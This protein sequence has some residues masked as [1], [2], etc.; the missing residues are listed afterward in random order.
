ME[1]ILEGNIRSLPGKRKGRE[2]RV[3]RIIKKKIDPLK[4]WNHPLLILEITVIKKK[5][6]LIYE[7]HMKIKLETKPIEKNRIKSSNF[8]FVKTGEIIFFR[9]RK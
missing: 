6:E 9:K 5:N 3:G 1:G 7:K 2:S 8:F 4:F